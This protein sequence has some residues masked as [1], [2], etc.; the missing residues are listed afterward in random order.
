MNRRVA[1][2]LLDEGRRYRFFGQ[3][4]FG[5]L[6]AEHRELVEHLGPPQVGLVA[7]FRRDLGDKHV[8]AVALGGKREHLHRDQVHDAAEGL[9]DVRRSGANRQVDRDRLAVE[10]VADLVE[11]AEIIGPFAVHLINERDPRHMVLV[12]LVPDG[13]ALGLDAFAGA[14]D[15]H[16][17]VEHPQAPLHFGGEIDVA[18]RVD[19]VDLNVLPGEGD[20]GG[21]DRDAPF[22]LFGVVI[23]DGGA[24]VDRA[25]AVAEAA[26]E[27]HPL[28]DG[29][30]ARVDM[31]NHADV[32]EVVNIGW[33][34]RL[35]ARLEVKTFM[36]GPPAAKVN[37]PRRMGSRCGVGKSACFGSH[38]P[39]T[40]DAALLIGEAGLLPP[41]QA[42]SS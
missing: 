10:P 18:G 4:Q 13:L 1:Q 30:L 2:H 35:A 17:A 9:F 33:H 14:E 20:R 15:H 23:G 24:L 36:V 26:V 42:G 41:R 40:P 16:A 8:A 38:R 28:G 31:G 29:G 12:G 21:V 5:Q 34:R 27:Q 25:Y 37:R 39:S 22:L 11:G 3:Q 32:A 19:Q 6:V 7:K